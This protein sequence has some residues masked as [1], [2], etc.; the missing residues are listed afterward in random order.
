MTSTH[1]IDAVTASPQHK[2]RSRRRRLIAGCFAWLFQSLD[3][4]LCEPRA[5]PVHGIHRVLVCRHNHRLG[6]TLLIGPLLAEIEHLY[7]GAEIDLLVSGTIGRSLYGDWFPVRD[8]ICLPRH[9][10]AHLPR[11]VCLLM[12]LRRTRY[13]L[14]IDACPESQSGRLL[15]SVARARYKVGDYRPPAARSA[16][17]R[18]V[19]RRSHLVGPTHLAHRGVFLLRAAYAGTPRDACPPLD[20]R[21]TGEERRRGANALHRLSGA[22]HSLSPP[23]VLGVFLS[24]TG[25][26]CYDPGWWAQLLDAVR[27][28]RPDM[29]VVEVLPDDGRSRAD[30]SLP[31]FY[32]R[33]VRKIAAVVSHM[34]GFVS[35]DC[36]IM[37]LA[38]ATGVP[39]VGLFSVTN[40]SRYAPYGHASGAIDTPRKT[41][42]EIAIEAVELIDRAARSRSPVAATTR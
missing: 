21:L 19:D 32:S 33:D 17:S 15:L 16:G 4:A 26:K 8:I 11:T 7:P 36:G 30:A 23:P 28:L 25:E 39:T 6:N 34:D 22:A 9:I 10:A 41:H 40:R 27:A 37:H 20:I 24:A 14:V 3:K 38:A 1:R 42:A 31:T 2:W 35:A 29:T 12:R 13:D 5:L 18:P